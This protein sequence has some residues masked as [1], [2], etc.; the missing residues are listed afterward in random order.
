[1]NK[2]DLAYIAGVIDSDGTIG[3][4]RNTYSMRVVGDSTQPTYSERVCLKQVEPHAVDLIHKLFGGSRYI[5]KPS[6]RRGRRLYTWQVTD[7]KAASF[8]QAIISFLLIKNKQ[9]R[10]CLKLRA[11]KNLSKNARKG[12][13]RKRL[14]QSGVEME[15]LYDLAH[16]LNHVGTSLVNKRQRRK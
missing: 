9:A 2:T 6:V 3:I 4:K 14:P 12:P 1:M 5:T 13:D 7:L 16:V 15:R 10:N 11:V 8:L